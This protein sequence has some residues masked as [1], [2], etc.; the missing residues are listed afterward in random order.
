MT[1]RAPG[2]TSRTSA[3]RLRRAMQVLHLAGIAP[4]Q[5]FLIERQLGKLVDRRDAA[6]VEAELD[7]ALASRRW[8]S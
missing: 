7:R 5:P 8:R 2:M 6:Q 4:G 1:D 3:R